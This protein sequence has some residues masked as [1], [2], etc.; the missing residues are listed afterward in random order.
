MGNVQLTRP[1]QFDPAS[2]NRRSMIAKANIAKSQL[3]MVE[4]DYRQLMFDTTGQTSLTKCSDDQVSRFLGAL[5]SKGFRPLPR[6]GQRGTAMHPMARKARALWIS[7]FHLG[8]V[9][10]SSEE[11]LEAFAKR[12]LKCEKLVWARQSNGG[13]L[14]EA[15]KDMAVRNGWEQADQQGVPF[16]P[17]GLQESLCNAI[18]KRLHR[19]GVIPAW[20]TL[21]NAAWSLCGIQTAQEQPFSAEQYAQLANALGAELRKAI[22]GGV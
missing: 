14:I 9:R 7:L 13:K 20:W 1:A 11:A 10:N 17:L 12:Q 18:V 3:A 15:L 22:G 6:A 5:K 21:D 2:Q 8:V 4:D 19:Q 16:Q